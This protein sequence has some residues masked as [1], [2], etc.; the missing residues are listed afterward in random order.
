MSAVG[1]CSKTSSDWS[2]QSESWAISSS[3]TGHRQ[4][5]T[6]VLARGNLDSV[7]VAQREAVLRY[8]GDRLVL[9]EDVVL[10]VQDTSCWRVV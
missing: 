9:A 6:F 5:E 4:H 2:A 8:A 1:G 3:A 7:G 10:V